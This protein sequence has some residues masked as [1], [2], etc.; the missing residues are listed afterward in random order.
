MLRRTVIGSLV[1]GLLMGAYARGVFASLIQDGAGNLRDAKAGASKPAY[2]SDRLLV[3][4]I[5]DAKGLP[6]PAAQ[7][8]AEPVYGLTK[9]GN[10]LIDRRLRS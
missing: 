5:D 3:I 7:A 4:F 10:F 2:A 8:R 6:A 1:F 9:I